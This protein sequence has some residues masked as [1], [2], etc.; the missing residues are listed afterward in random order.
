MYNYERQEEFY[1]TYK[2]IIYKK[3]NSVDNNMKNPDK[4]LKEEKYELR[5]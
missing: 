4:K 5:K 2:E 3:L 1:E